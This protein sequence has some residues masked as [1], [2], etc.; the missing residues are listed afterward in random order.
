MPARIKRIALFLS[1]LCFF[2]GVANLHS[3]DSDNTQA[4]DDADRDTSL[5][6]SFAQF[7][8]FSPILNA[9]GQPDFQT[10]VLTNPLVINRE[11]IFGFRFKVPLRTN[12]EDLVWAF[13][14]PGDF[15]EWYILPQTG[16]MNGFTN[17][18]YQTKGEYMGAKPLLPMA[19]NRLIFQYLTG[20]SL[21]DGQT[22]LIWFGFG[23]R[24]P[25]AMSLT[26][27][28][29]NFDSTDPHPLMA[30]QK[31]FSLGQL[32]SAPIV[33]SYNHHIYMLLRPTTWERSE[34]FAE[35]M[36][37]HLATVRNQQEEDWI[38]KAFGDYGGE[39]R[40]L[41][42]GLNDLDKRFHFSWASGE[43]AS[44]TDWA[45]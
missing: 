14:E 29:T 4:S 39:R 18:Y 22:Y 44:Y 42:I 33:N 45:P 26:F 34:K 7:P 5:Q 36:G 1:V 6:K 11:R 21:V 8:F 3:Q 35:K 28:F 25:P 37:G 2:A 10:L 12:Q 31:V 27:T 20:D 19:G 17:Y 30:F 9:G 32:A 16:E 43:S 40:L 15:K 41:W 13:V 23:N 24:N 38:F